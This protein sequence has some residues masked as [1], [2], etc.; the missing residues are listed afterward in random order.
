MPSVQNFSLVAGELTS[1]KR[2]LYPTSSPCVAKD[3]HTSAHCTSA[4]SGQAHQRGARFFSDAASEA[5]SSHAAGLRD[6]NARAF[7]QQVALRRKHG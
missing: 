7:A 4:Q 6:C 2:M 3:V 5:H 1:S